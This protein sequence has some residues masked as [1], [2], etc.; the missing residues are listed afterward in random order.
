M[1]DEL[2]RER[3]ELVASTRELAELLHEPARFVDRRVE[4]LHAMSTTSAHW[5]VRLQFTSLES[6]RDPS[7]GEGHRVVSLGIFPKKRLPDMR[8]V[9]G[10]GSEVPLVRRDRRARSLAALLFNRLREVEEATEKRHLSD[11]GQLARRL[12]DVVA[13][14]PADAAVAFGAYAAQVREDLGS[15]DAVEAHLEFVENFVDLTHVLG[16]VRV[17]PGGFCNV[18]FEYTDRHPYPR[19]PRWSAVKRKGEGILTWWRLTWRYFAMQAGLLAVPFNTRLTGA[20]HAHSFYLLVDAPPGTE[21]EMMQWKQLDYRNLI[22]PGEVHESGSSVLACYDP[23]HDVHGGDA[24]I[25]LRINGEHLRLVWLLTAGIMAVAMAVAVNPHP[26]GGY[27][28][29]ASLFAAMPA[30]ILALLTQ[31]DSGLVVRIS[32]WLR[33]AYVGLAASTAVLGLAMVTDLL[34]EAD[35]ADAPFL[36]DRSAGAVTALFATLLFVLT[37]DIAFRRPGPA[38]THWTAVCKDRRD[39]FAAEY[40]RRRRRSAVITP[41]IA[42]VV[43]VVEAILLGSLD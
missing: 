8:A 22:A 20:N 41:A 31:R 12:L 9:D 25:R 10:E 19:M 28:T 37:C 43:C 27:G 1:H 29:V 35:W 15:T 2:V 18:T 32:K 5:R 11:R 7:V 24:Q 6:E 33:R 21:V 42:I 17:S 3:R 16:L 38:V 36:S 14:N 4:H 34:P 30:A 13:K 26:N 23:E 39:P 40:R